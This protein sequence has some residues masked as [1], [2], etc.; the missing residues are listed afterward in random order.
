MPSGTWNPSMRMPTMILS[1]GNKVA[2]LN[3]D[4]SVNYS[5]I[6]CCAGR[7]TGKWYFEMLC[8]GLFSTE[9]VFAGLAKATANISPAGFWLDADAWGYN[10]ENGY[11]YHNGSAAYGA[12]YGDADVIGVAWDADAGKIWWA[13]NNTWQASGAPAAGTGAAYT[14]ATGTLYPLGTAYVGD[15]QVWTLRTLASE[16]TY[17]P[18]SGFSPWTHP[19]TISLTVRDENGAAIASTAF[20]W[21]FFDEAT[22]DAL[23]TPTATGTTST[24]GSGV[25]AITIPDT[26]LANGATGSLLISTTGGVAGVQCRSWYMPVTVTV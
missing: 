4:Y 2:T 17:S 25:L 18:P 22:P 11:T 24:N 6:L 9:N 7:S 13:K 20:D 26:S 19:A 3:L 8:G 21:A 12:T 16:Q 14:N 1:A 10:G 23:T 15:Q 5:S